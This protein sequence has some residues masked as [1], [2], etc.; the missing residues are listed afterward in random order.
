MVSAVGEELYCSDPLY[1]RL[2]QP[3]SSR[4]AALLLFPIC[5]CVVIHV[6]NSKRS[7]FCKLSEIVFFTP[8]VPT[9]HLKNLVLSQTYKGRFGLVA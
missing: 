5:V 8:P 3:T 4:M 7:K 9:I 6:T 2:I 1:H